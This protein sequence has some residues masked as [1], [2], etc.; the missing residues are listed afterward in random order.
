MNEVLEI[1]PNIFIIDFSLYLKKSSTLIISDL[2]IGYEEALNKKGFLIP[3]FQ[4]KDIFSRLDK[5]MDF[6]KPKLVVI[7]GDIKHEFSVISKTEWKNIL[8]LVDFIKKRSDL[9]LIKGNHDNLLQRIIKKDNLELLDYYF[10]DN[11][12][13][14]HGNEILKND[15]IKK[16]DTIVIGHEHPAIALREKGRVEKFKCFLK[17]FYNY[18]KIKKNL[19]VL[20]SFNTLT[21]GTD[22]LSEKL[23]SPFLKNID[24][25]DIFLI[26][27]LNSNQLNTNDSF[28]NKELHNKLSND[29]LSEILYFGKVKSFLE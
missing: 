9:I 21:E 17:G 22:I 8:E 26:N 23:M 1:L 3:R 13:I 11:V 18:N 2:Q 12:F 10:I 20:P 15:F 5:L 29:D 7:N 6:L 25:F 16:S 14:C 19:I 4:K 27:Q 28:N 24:D